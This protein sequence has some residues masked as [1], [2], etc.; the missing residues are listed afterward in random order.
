MDEC[1]MLSANGRSNARSLA[2]LGAAIVSGKGEIAEA[3]A[4][5]I[6]YV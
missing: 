3:C 1:E 2:A 6:R 4:E 5:A